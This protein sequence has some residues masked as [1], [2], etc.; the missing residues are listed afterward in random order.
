MF[1][2]VTKVFKFIIK[3]WVKWQNV[4]CFSDG[5]IGIYQFCRFEDSFIFDYVE[6]NI[7]NNVK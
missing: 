6:Y 2:L 3:P 5:D 4:F 7:Q 1:I